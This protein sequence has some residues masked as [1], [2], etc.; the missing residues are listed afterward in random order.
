MKELN[1]RETLYGKKQNKK[2]DEIDPR[3]REIIL[4]EQ[5]EKEAQ[6]LDQLGLTNKYNVNDPT[7]L[8]V[9]RFDIR[10]TDQQMENEIKLRDQR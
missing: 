6:I 7:F 3:E 9:P 4:K 1:R 8:S 2:D 10:I 5:V